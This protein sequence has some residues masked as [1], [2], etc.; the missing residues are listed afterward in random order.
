MAEETQAPEADDEEKKRGRQTTEAEHAERVD[1][2]AEMWVLHR[3]RHQQ[4]K[5]IAD[6]CKVTFRQAQDY[7]T[8]AKKRAR[9]ATNKPADEH[10]ARH[11]AVLESI[12]CSTEAAR[13]R[14]Q[15]QKQL[16][17]LLG[18]QK[19]QEQGTDLRGLVEDVVA[20]SPGMLA[21]AAAWEP[22]KVGLLEGPPEAAAQ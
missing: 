12:M 1:F 8:A 6:Q 18:L 21:D 20:S 13:N 14:L 2:A 17:R 16:A 11:V 19:Q 7:L 9:K 22:P 15:A 5:A 3:T 10:L 4:L